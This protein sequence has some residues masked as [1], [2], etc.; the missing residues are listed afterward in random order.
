MLGFKYLVHK[1]PSKKYKKL[2]S[3]AI[4]VVNNYGVWQVHVILHKEGTSSNAASVV[5]NLYNVKGYICL[6]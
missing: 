6:H 1:F 4:K 3:L 5:F 2:L